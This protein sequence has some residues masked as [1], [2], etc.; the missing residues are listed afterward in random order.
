MRG[1]ALLLFGLAAV[2]GF[3]M[4]PRAGAGSK[5]TTTITSRPTPFVTQQQ[6]H[7]QQQQHCPMHNGAGPLMMSASAEAPAKKEETFE[8][9]AEVA[10]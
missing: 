6:Q 5:F 9:Q 7:Q 1:A 8:F 3:F 2:D 4:M 10:R